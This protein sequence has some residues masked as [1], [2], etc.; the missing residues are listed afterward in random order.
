MDHYVVWNGR[1][2]L[3]RPDS[4]PTLAVACIR[5]PWSPMSLRLILQRAA[6]LSEGFGLRPDAVRKAIWALQGATPASYFLVRARPLGE[7]VAV[8]DVPRPSSWPK[9][10]R[11]G[12]IVMSRFS[13]LDVADPEPAGRL[14][15]S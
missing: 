12:D 5:S 10:V 13:R 3:G 6:E 11:A 9:P 14:L 7:Y 1:Q 15:A 8:T 2:R 4:V